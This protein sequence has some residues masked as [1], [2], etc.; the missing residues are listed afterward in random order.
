[1]SYDRD[2]LED[3]RRGIVRWLLDVAFGR[4]GD[5]D[6]EAGEKIHRIGTINRRLE[7]DD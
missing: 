1:M 5:D 6:G 2:D 3:E 7:D 4:S